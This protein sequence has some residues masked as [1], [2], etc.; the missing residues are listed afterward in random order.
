MN[1]K[2][3]AIEI[4]QLLG[5]KLEGNP[6][7]LVWKPAKIEEGEQGAISFF[8]NPKYEEYIYTTA[9][10]VLLLPEDFQLKQ[11]I[12]ATIIRLKDVYASVS[13]LMQHFEALLNPANNKPNEIIISP[14]AFVH[15]ST[16][17]G[18]G[19]KIDAFAYIGQD[20]KIGKNVTIYPQVWIESGVEIG[21]N[22]TLY[23]GV[24]VYK[25]SFIGKNCII[26]ANAVVGADGFGFAPQADGTYHKIPQ[27]GIA[28]I[29]DNVEIGANTV[30]DRAVMGKTY[31]AKG[32][33]LDNLIQIAHNVSIG[34]NT[35]MAAQ[36]G[37][38]GSTHIGANCM[39]GGQV[40]FA[41]HLKIADGVQIQAQS[42]IAKNIKQANSYW[43]GA[44]AI[45]FENFMRSS[46]VFKNLPQLQKTVDELVK[47]NQ[48]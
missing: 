13:V 29:D 30:I 21:D 33:K 43:G 44:P 20:S 38:A 28:Y 25:G 19:T 18:E 10:S 48:K 2:V 35:V 40:G 24:K 22:T 36:A 46:I 42:G 16:I 7:V 23:A 41:G 11:P 31:I 39:I 1:F 4:C 3:K 12:A 14:Q 47:A 8:A 6:D 32:V 9:S 37:V 17:V 15:Q 5:G 27:L 34:E 45:P 26:H